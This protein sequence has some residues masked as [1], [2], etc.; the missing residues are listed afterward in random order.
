MSPSESDWL[1][2]PGSERLATFA[3]IET[4]GLDCLPAGPNTA[5]I[6]SVVI[7]DSRLKGLVCSALSEVT[8]GVERGLS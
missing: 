5:V 2:P 1:M 8:D 3:V 6:G 7:G 4:R